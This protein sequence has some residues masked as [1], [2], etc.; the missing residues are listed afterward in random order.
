MARSAA[1]PPACPCTPI[2]LRMPT[3]PGPAA[4][5]A[6]TRP[7]PGATPH[8]AAAGVV[9]GDRGQARHGPQRRRPARV[10]LHAHQRADADR[11]GHGGELGEQAHLAGVDPADLGGA[12]DGPPGED[13]VA[14]LLP[15]ERAP[16]E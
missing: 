11:P 3:R 14:E 4:G 9:A 7:S 15:A 12:L 8:T 16:L 13:A 10:P 5:P 1:P 6:H 2:S